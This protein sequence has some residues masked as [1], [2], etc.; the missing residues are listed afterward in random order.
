M[1]NK[2]NNLPIYILSVAM[3]QL[4]KISRKCLALAAICTLSFTIISCSSDEW[5]P[6]EVPEDYKPVF[7]EGKTWTYGTVPRSYIGESSSYTYTISGDTVVKGKKYL[8]LYCSDKEAYGDTDQHYFAAVRE[9]SLR[10]FYVYKD[11]KEEKLLFDFGEDMDVD[12]EIG[13]LPLCYV[14]MLHEPIPKNFL[15]TQRL[16][17]S[18]AASNKETGTTALTCYFWYEGIGNNPDLLNKKHF[19]WDNYLISCYENGRCIYDRD[20]LPLIY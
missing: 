10:T 6:R 14:K 4:F 20:L 5:E 16:V 1:G 17:F 19:N 18:W 8:K 13:P 3:K 9:E 15:G 2:S 11:D 7:K 12:F